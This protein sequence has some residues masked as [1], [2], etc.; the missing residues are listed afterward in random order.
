LALG[1]N[2][3]ATFVDDPKAVPERFCIEQRKYTREYCEYVRLVV[4]SYSQH[5]NAGVVS[6]RVRVHIREVEIE[7]DK[8][9]PFALT[10]ISNV[11][12]RSSA[13]ALIHDSHGVVSDVPKPDG[14]FDG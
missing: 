3:D 8:R 14:D 7:R 13:E 12:V 10:D 11:G 9:A 5:D 1:S 2:P 4:L 6:W